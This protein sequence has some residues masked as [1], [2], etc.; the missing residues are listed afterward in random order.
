MRRPL[1]NR[2]N[3]SVRKATALKDKI[4][5]NLKLDFS[6]KVFILVDTNL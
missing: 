6:K 4:K 5:D 3:P 2:L 1:K